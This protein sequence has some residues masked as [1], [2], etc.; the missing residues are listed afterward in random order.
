MHKIIRLVGKNKIEV[1]HCDFIKKYIAKL[2]FT[3]KNGYSYEY[4][5]ES[6]SWTGD[7]PYED[8]VR[9]GL[10]KCGH[11]NMNPMLG[12]ENAQIG[13]QCTICGKEF[14]YYNSSLL[15]HHNSAFKS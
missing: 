1:F 14:P 13:E 6:V 12:Y 15:S 10:L 11:E 8:C 5:A 4:R 3:T 7:V 9:I 2:H